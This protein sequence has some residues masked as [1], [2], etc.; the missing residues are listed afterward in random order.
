M[1][2]ICGVCSAVSC[3]SGPEFGSRYVWD[4]KSPMLKKF[5]S[6]LCGGLS[7]QERFSRATCSWWAPQLPEQQVLCQSHAICF[8]ADPGV[9]CMQC[10]FCEKNG[11]RG[12]LIKWLFNYLFI[13]H[14]HSFT[15]Y[16][17]SF[18]QIPSDCLPAHKYLSKGMG[19]NWLT[20]TGASTYGG[21]DIGLIPYSEV[22]WSWLRSCTDPLLWE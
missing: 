1:S 11:C 7:M 22:L 19:L 2:V 6:G 9:F 20:H 18:G 15:L 21:T 3:A 4:V 17:P 5:K 10:L 14:A 12:A 8:R 13:Q 16:S